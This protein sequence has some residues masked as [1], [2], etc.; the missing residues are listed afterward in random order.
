MVDG[1]WLVDEPLLPKFQLQEVG[2]PVERSVNCTTM[3][4]HPLTGAPEKFAFTCEKE[5]EKE[6]RHP[7]NA[8]RQQ[9]AEEKQEMIFL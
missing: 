4:A 2:P 1:F 6:N 9:L 8:M 3:G 5:E 7:T